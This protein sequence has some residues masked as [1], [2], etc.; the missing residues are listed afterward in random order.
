[1]ELRISLDGRRR[2]HAKAWRQI[3]NTRHI[4]VDVLTRTTQP[5]RGTRASASRFPNQKLRQ[6]VTT[7]GFLSKEGGGSSLFSMAS[8]QGF[9]PRYADPESAVLPFLHVPAFFQSS[10]CFP[11][12]SVICG[13]SQALNINPRPAMKIQ[14]NGASKAKTLR[15]KLRRTS[16]NCPCKRRDL[17]SRG[18]DSMPLSLPSFAHGRGG[19]RKNSPCRLPCASWCVRVHSQ[20]IHLPVPLPSARA[21]APG[22]EPAPPIPDLD[23]ESGTAT[24]ARGFWRQCRQNLQAMPVNV[25]DNS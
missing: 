10:L 5:A 7:D 17:Q 19:T 24:A 8:P 21:L 23:Y 6:N 12:F 25:T 2:L 22:Q 13:V 11:F 15:Q 1:V 20:F 4:T 9:E 16:P 18:W 14:K 3:L